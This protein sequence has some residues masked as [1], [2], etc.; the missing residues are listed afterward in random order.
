MF[1]KGCANGIFYR[2]RHKQFARIGDIL[3][4]VLKSAGLEQRLREQ[5]ILAIWPTVVGEDI[6]ARTKAVRIE[7]GVLHVYVEHGAW[8]QELYFMEKELI[9]KLRDSAPEIECRK[10]RFSCRDH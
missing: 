3:P 5:K 2:M 7:K 10:I 9:R 4:A 6:A 8:M 1:H